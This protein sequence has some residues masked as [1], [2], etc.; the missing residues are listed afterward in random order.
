MTMDWIVQLAFAWMVS[1]PDE[2]KKEEKRVK[3]VPRWPKGCALAISEMALREIGTEA[4]S[5]VFNPTTGEYI[6][7]VID[8]KGEVKSFNGR[9]NRDKS[10]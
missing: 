8:E 6:A 10:A 5:R 2:P 4:K 3:V 9:E 7:H 1:D